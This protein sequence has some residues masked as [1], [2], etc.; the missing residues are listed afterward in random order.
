MTEP[1]GF[2][3]GEHQYN[4]KLNPRYYEDICIHEGYCGLYELYKTKFI[5][6]N[7]YTNQDTNNRIRIKNILAT[8][9]SPSFRNQGPYQTLFNTIYRADCSAQ[10]KVMAGSKT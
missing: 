3:H 9:N 5:L 1:P 8:N 6:K 4:L 2:S 7:I 10:T